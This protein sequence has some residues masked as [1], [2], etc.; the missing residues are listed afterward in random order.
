M[1]MSAVLAAAGIVAAATLTAAV[2]ASADPIGNQLGAIPLISQNNGT[3]AGPINNHGLSDAGT[4]ASDL[5]GRS[6]GAAVNQ[7]KVVDV[8]D[9]TS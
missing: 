2:P 8:P 5:T 9:V 7:L 4:F 1:R 6:E 3:N